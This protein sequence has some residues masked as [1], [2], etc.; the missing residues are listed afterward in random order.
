[1]NALRKLSLRSIVVVPLIAPA[2]DDLSR[3]FF[4]CQPTRAPHTQY[5][6]S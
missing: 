1:M 3:A 4:E 6:K 5:K 2:I